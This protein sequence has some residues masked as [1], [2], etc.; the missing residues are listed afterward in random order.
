MLY[1]SLDFAHVAT[2]VKIAIHVK[3]A[4]VEWNCATVSLSEITLS[5]ISLPLLTKLCFYFI[6]S[7]RIQEFHRQVNSCAADTPMRPPV[8]R[9]FCFD[10][11]S[12]LR[13]SSLRMLQPNNK[14]DPLASFCTLATALCC[15]WHKYAKSLSVDYHSN[16]AFDGNVGLKT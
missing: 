16:E 12:A 1:P 11:I 13:I 4:F 3:D 10:P 6:H 15:E 14:V 7:Y 5:E 2:T 8:P 9:V